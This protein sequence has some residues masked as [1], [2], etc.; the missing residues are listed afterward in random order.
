MF[1][2]IKKSSICCCCGK[3]NEKEKSILLKKK[4]KTKWSCVIRGNL[5]RFDSAR[6]GTAFLPTAGS[7]RK[8]IPGGF[9][10][11]FHPSTANHGHVLWP[12]SSRQIPVL[13][14]IFREEIFEIAEN[15]YPEVVQTFMRE[16]PEYFTETPGWWKAAFRMEGGFIFYQDTKLFIKYIITF[17]EQIIYYSNFK[18]CQL[19]TRRCRHWMATGNTSINFR[20]KWNKSWEWKYTTYWSK[21]WMMKNSPKTAEFNQFGRSVPTRDQKQDK[22]THPTRCLAPKQIGALPDERRR[23]QWPVIDG[24]RNSGKGRK[25]DFVQALPQT[26]SAKKRFPRKN[27]DVRHALPPQTAPSTTPRPSMARSAVWL[28]SSSKSPSM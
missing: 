12:G 1:S 19:K 17:C 9:G 20:D 6:V 21:V 4:K 26:A 7:G 22:A 2:S 5:Q 15:E 8:D 25:T 16:F 13:F 10:R 14:W 23:K 3:K 11:H 27:E 24:E 18:E 28:I